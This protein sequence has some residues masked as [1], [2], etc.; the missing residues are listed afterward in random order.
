VM[1]GSNVLMVR[2]VCTK[3]ITLDDGARF[4][5]DY[6]TYKNMKYTSG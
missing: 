3:G 4:Q 1:I 5:E 6:N 2:I